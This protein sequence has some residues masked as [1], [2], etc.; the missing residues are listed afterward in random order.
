ML[1]LSRCHNADGEW[2]PERQPMAETL[3]AMGSPMPTFDRY[4]FA[5]TLYLKDRQQTPPTAKK[6]HWDG[7]TMC[8][9]LNQV[10]AGEIPGRW[11]LVTKNVFASLPPGKRCVNCNKSYLLTK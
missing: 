9:A 10:N 3:R 1:V 6:L 4:S 5:K 7:S 8:S 11:R 2:V